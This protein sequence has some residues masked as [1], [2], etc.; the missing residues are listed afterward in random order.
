M[1]SSW[2]S[3]LQALST[4]CV[5][6]VVCCVLC[7]IK[8]LTDQRCDQFMALPTTGLVNTLCAVCC[9]LCVV[10]LCVVCYKEFNRP[11]L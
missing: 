10:C 5:L 3:L 1:I 9:V 2:R 4:R 11:M 6:C 8:S 7:V